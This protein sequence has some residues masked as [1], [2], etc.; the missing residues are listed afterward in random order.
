[1]DKCAH[2]GISVDATSVGPIGNDALP[3]KS[4]HVLFT[5]AALDP[6]QQE[7][8]KLILKAERDWSP[9]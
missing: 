1:M 2:A 9:F 3:S 7:Q 8:Q 4:L 6:L 5:L